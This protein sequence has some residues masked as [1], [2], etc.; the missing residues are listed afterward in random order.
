MKYISYDKLCIAFSLLKL[1]YIQHGS[2]FLQCMLY[3]EIK[4]SG[5]R[6]TSCTHVP[7]FVHVYIYSKQNSCWTNKQTKTMNLMEIYRS[8]NDFSSGPHTSQDIVSI[9]SPYHT[10]DKKKNSGSP[11]AATKKKL[12]YRSMRNHYQYLLLQKN[13]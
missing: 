5:R 7:K 2:K 1:P 12:L 6:K 11:Q 4:S 13:Q 3:A 9:T 10:I 8:I